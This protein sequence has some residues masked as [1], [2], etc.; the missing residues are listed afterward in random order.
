MALMH[1]Q[2]KLIRFALPIG[3]AL[4]LS[5]CAGAG[6][7]WTYAPLGPTAAPT[8]AATA[9]PAPSGSGGPA[10]TIE[11]KTTD[12][13]PLVFEPAM[14]EAPANTSITVNYTND[15]ALP[16]NIDFFSG[17]DQTSDSLAKTAVVTGPGAVESV[18]FTTPAAPGDYFFWC[19]VHTTAMIGM[20]HVTQ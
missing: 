15:S 19:D 20:L 7:G 13:N 8:S 10:I 2:P 16:H 14:I 9:T 1:P 18:T 6:P 17:A 4:I 11:V 5:A 3:V 12:A